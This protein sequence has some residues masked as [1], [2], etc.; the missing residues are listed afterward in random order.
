MRSNEQSSTAVTNSPG[1]GLLRR[2]RL[3]LVLFVLL[4]TFGIAARW[5]LRSQQA[6]DLVRARLQASYGG[7][8]QVATVELGLG[9]SSIRGLRLFQAGSQ[10]SDDPWLVIDEAHMD[11]S[12]L[13]LL[14]GEPASVPVLLTGVVLTLRYDQSGRLLT[15]L[16]KPGEKVSHF[17]SL[18][19]KSARVRLLQEGHPDFEI[20]EI[21]GQLHAE[22]DR[23]V[24]TGTATDPAWGDWAVTGS[25]DPITET[26]TMRMTAARV[27]LTQ[28]MLSSLPF[29]PAKV[30]RQVQCEGDTP[31]EL[32]VG[33]DLLA[34]KRHYRV[35]LEPE[36][37][38]VHI[39]SINLYA[40]RAHGKVAIEDGVVKLEKVSGHSADGQIG[41]SGIL[42]FHA[43]PCQLRFSVSAEHLDL[44]LLPKS[45]HLPPTLKGRLS[46]QA[47]LLVSIA[48]GKPLT[49]G[50]GY[51]TVTETRIAA[52]PVRKPIPVKLHADGK[53]FHFS[54]GRQNDRNSSPP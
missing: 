46:G 34:K 51:G 14:N 5:Y 13:T 10:P 11:A 1:T 23:L 35:N 49:S 6:T 39:S 31:V 32:V 42:D 26:T 43:D 40:D 3:L 53:R 28:A 33:S 50:D 15:E 54:P 48:D 18:S 2:W 45:W 29:V 9:S 4:C 19:F 20:A 21:G 38:K 36:S 17:P 22:G 27:H 37:T 44:S 24:L 8:L 30:W 25:M 12:L 52:V 47:E 7:P 41:T 16:P